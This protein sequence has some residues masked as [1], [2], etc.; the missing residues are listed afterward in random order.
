MVHYYSEHQTSPLKLRKIN[1]FLRNNNLE[2]YTGSGIF[3]PD[4]VDFG[5]KLLIESCIIK[6]DWD[7]LDLGCGYGAVGISIAKAFPRAR[8]FMTDINKRAVKLALK[9]ITL[10]NIKAEVKQGGLFEKIK[11]KFDTILVNPPQKAG[12]EICFSMIEQSFGYLKDGGLLQ[13]V[14]RHN[15]G[16]KSLKKKMESVF[17]NIET[18]EKKKGYSVYISQKLTTKTDR[19][20]I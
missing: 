14:A 17:K 16:G 18:M 1:A 2:F 11:E 15:K 20:N 8:V 3:S 19:K 6:P 4:K 12:K 10:N 13:L 5:S 7:I 9:N